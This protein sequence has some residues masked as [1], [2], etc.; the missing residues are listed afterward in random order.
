MEWPPRRQGGRPGG[1]TLDPRHG[2]GVTLTWFVLK[3][4]RSKR[5]RAVRA[6]VCGRTLD[7][8]GGAADNQRHS[9]E[10]HS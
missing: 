7:G 6:E 8:E 2:F 10:S 3:T 5:I 4:R 9:W 1:A